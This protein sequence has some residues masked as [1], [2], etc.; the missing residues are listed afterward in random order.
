MAGD[1]RGGVASFVRGRGKGLAVLAQS[2]GYPFPRPFARR[3]T[4]SRVRLAEAIEGAESIEG[5]EGV[6]G[7][8]GDLYD[9]GVPA[10]AILLV[11]G[12]A[13]GGAED[14]AFVRLARSFAGARRTV[15]VPDL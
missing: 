3:V 10:P 8:E 5:V 6:D 11:P 4:Q 13:P 2:A 1:R 9:P 12:G 7:V 15:F 14:P